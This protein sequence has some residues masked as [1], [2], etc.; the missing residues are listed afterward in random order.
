MNSLLV[1][2]RLVDT[3]TAARLLGLA[4]RTVRERAPEFGGF[5]VG[6]KLWKFSLATLNAYIAKRK[7]DVDKT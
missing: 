5:K 6:P 4:R 2:D 3:A 1:D 7:S